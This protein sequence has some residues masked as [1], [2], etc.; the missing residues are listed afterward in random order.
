MGFRKNHHQDINSSVSVMSNLKTSRKVV[1]FP[2]L[3][4]WWLFMAVL[5][6][7]S[8]NIAGKSHFSSWNFSYHLGFSLVSYQLD[9]CF[10]S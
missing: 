10:L 9:E 3:P 5:F 6:L 8:I 1:I 4:K 7:S 2:N